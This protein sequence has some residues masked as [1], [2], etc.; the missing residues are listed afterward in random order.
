MSEHGGYQQDGR[1][2]P[3]TPGERL[4]YE[5]GHKDARLEAEAETERLRTA[6]ADVAA[7]AAQMA[8]YARM[9]GH[10]ITSQKKYATIEELA[11][12][13]MRRVREATE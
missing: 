13:L 5:Q 6:L 2:V 8:S 10:E 7:E 9:F 12:R 4:A 11:H 1:W 3:G